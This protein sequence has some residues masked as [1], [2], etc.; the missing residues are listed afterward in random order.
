MKTKSI[1]PLLALVILV[2]SCSKSPTNGTNGAQGPAGP[3]F[4]GSL[5]GH[6]FLTNQYGVIADTGIAYTGIRAILYN[7]SNNQ[8]VD[9]V[10]VKSSG[11]YTFPTVTTGI[12][13][14]AFRDTNYGQSLDQGFQFIG[15][16]NLELPN[17][18]CAHIPNFNI[19]KVDF[20]SINHAQSVVVFADT[21]SP[22]PKPRMLAIFIGSAANVS[23]AP[24]NYLT[25]YSYTLAAN[26][27]RFLVRIPLTTIYNAGIGS[28][29]NAYFAIYGASYDYTTASEYQDYTTGRNI[30]N[31]ISA[32]AVTTLPTQIVMP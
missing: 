29:S 11:V 4:T 6:F 32:T 5:T 16:G 9:S 14:I 21:I 15:P 19:I 8:V 3:S 30:Y 18:E 1:L 25:V 7:Q 24:A 31:A 28:G 12:Y 27:T 20:D 13:T 23:S 17:K 10:N 22:D 26:A 2:A